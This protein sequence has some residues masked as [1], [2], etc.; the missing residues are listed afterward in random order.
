MFDR[1]ENNSVEER[2]TIA[3]H[4]Y[5]G[6]IVIAE[7]SASSAATL[8]NFVGEGIAAGSQYVGHAQDAQA[9]WDQV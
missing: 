1:V 5:R 6:G 7:A 3:I 4:F 2:L 8:F 9:L